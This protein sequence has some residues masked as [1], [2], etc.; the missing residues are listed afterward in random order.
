MNLQK[1]PKLQMV[2]ITTHHPSH[3]DVIRRSLMKEEMTVA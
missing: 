1:E 3:N 2:K